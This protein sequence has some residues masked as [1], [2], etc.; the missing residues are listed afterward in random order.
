[1]RLGQHE[2]CAALP[3]DY[4]AVADFIETNA[5]AG[6]KSAAQGKRLTGVRA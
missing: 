4:E 5:R 6:G 3:N 2:R 1:L